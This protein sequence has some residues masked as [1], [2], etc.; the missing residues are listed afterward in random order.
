M[1]TLQETLE[2]MDSD[3]DGFIDVKEFLSEEF[4]H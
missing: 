3:G 4:I 2:E 1:F